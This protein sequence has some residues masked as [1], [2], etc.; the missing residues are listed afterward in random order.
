[1]AANRKLDPST[2]VTAVATVDFVVELPRL[3]EVGEVVTTGETVIVIRTKNL[4]QDAFLFFLELRRLEFSGRLTGRRD[5]SS[6]HLL[7]LMSP[8]PVRLYL[9]TST[10]TAPVVAWEGS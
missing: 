9:A 1:M 6:R 10:S 7:I 3:A 8:N 4:S 2:L 5:S